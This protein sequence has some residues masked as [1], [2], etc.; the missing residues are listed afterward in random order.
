MAPLAVGVWSSGV[1]GQRSPGPIDPLVILAT[2]VIAFIV[3]V[4][5]VT[6][7][8][9]RAG[10]WQ[11]LR[12]LSHEAGVGVHRSTLVGET[13]AWWSFAAAIVSG[14]LGWIAVAIALGLVGSA[15]RATGRP[16][17]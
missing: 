2:L 1:D 12:E 13:L 9:V 3:S 6:W 5:V 4:R 15:L 10:R 7:L 14:L 11:L 8:S 16:R 17:R